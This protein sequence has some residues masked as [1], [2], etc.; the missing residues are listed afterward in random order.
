MDRRL[1]R[2]YRTRIANSILAGLIFPAIF[3]ALLYAGPPLPA[4]EGTEVWTIGK[5][6]GSSIEFAPGSKPKI[7]FVVGQ[8]TPEKDFPANQI[9][10]VSPDSMS[11]SGGSPY[12]ISFDLKQKP[13]CAYE[14]VLDLIFPA[15][16]PSHLKI[17]VNQK[18]GIFPLLPE[19]KKDVD[20]NEAN[21]MLLACFSHR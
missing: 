17:Q 20:S 3:I 5:P 1:D 4:D 6:D 2:S 18:I 15:A 10:S 11:P 14:L 21:S 9:G 19:P 13:A 7:N 8:S 16:A 12:T